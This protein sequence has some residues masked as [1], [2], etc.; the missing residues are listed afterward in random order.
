MSRQAIKTGPTNVR[1]SV[2]AGPLESLRRFEGACQMN[3]LTFNNAQSLPDLDLVNQATLSQIA[4]GQKAHNWVIVGLQWFN[5]RHYLTILASLATPLRLAKIAR[6][7]CQE[8]HRETWQLRA[9][10]PPPLLAVT[11]AIEAELFPIALASLDNSELY[12][13]G[14]VEKKCI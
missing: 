10:A 6:G 13:S 4:F 2:Y 7:I 9:R 1:A 12:G 5:F 3:N 8:G 14:A 11:R